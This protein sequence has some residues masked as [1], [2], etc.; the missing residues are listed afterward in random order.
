M[1][2]H[3]VVVW[4]H[5]RPEALQVVLEDVPEPG[6]REVRVKVLAAGVSA[7]DPHGSRPLVPRVSD[8]G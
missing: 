5:G 3:R 8:A 2:Q 7:F 1:K 6:T 4:R